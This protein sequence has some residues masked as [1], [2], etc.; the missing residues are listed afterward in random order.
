MLGSRSGAS[1]GAKAKGATGATNARGGEAVTGAHAVSGAW[2]SLLWSAAHYALLPAIAPEHAV[3][4]EVARLCSAHGRR[5]SLCALEARPPP[6]ARGELYAAQPSFAPVLVGPPGAVHGVLPVSALLETAGPEGALLLWV[7]TAGRSGGLPDGV[8]ATPLVDATL[9]LDERG[10]V[11][12]AQGVWQWHGHSEPLRR[13]RPRAGSLRGAAPWRR[14]IEPLPE[15]VGMAAAAILFATLTSENE[16]R[17]AAQLLQRRFAVSRM[18]RRLKMLL[19]E[20]RGADSGTRARTA[21]AAADGGCHSRH[22]DTQAMEP[23]APCSAAL[24]SR[25][26]RSRD[27]AVGSPDGR[28]RSLMARDGCGRA[29]RARAGCAAFASC[30]HAASMPRRRSPPPGGGVTAC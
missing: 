5:A 25:A 26:P 6:N 13:Q 10:A 24:R 29:M 14:G 17:R 21:L 28:G 30:A 19:K 11:V 1:G 7:R 20:S 9:R 18:R 27:R 23:D 3:R 16:R 2:L 12:R 22:G 8:A 4:A 15:K